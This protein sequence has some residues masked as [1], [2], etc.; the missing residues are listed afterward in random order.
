MEL[1]GFPISTK[2]RFDS[3]GAPQETAEKG[4]LRSDCGRRANWRS[5]FVV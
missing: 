1:L 3:N 2:P 4:M 5:W